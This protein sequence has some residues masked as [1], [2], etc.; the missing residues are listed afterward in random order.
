MGGNT[1]RNLNKFKENSLPITTVMGV[2]T[3]VV[4]TPIHA[5][6]ITDTVG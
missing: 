2:I 3:A 4:I 6:V 1:I 5:A